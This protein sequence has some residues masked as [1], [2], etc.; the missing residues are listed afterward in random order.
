[1]APKFGCDLEHEVTLVKKFQLSDLLVDLP[2]TRLIGPDVEIQGLACDSRRIKGGELF[3]ALPGTN[4]DGRD[5]IPAALAAGA[6]ALV[7]PQASA[8]EY[9]VPVV[10]GANVRLLMAKIA[11]RFYGDP[12][13]GALVIGITGTNG[14]TTI[15]YLLE[16]IFKQAG[17]RPAVFGTI[18]YRYAER[19]LLAAHTTPESLDLVRMMAEFRAAGANVLI[20]EVSSHALA[21][22]RVAGVHF[23]IAVFTNLTPEHL[24]YHQDME[25]YFA[26]KSRLFAQQPPPAMVVNL[27]D[28]YGV[29]LKKL[30]PQALGYARSASAELGYEELSAGLD[31]QRGT[32]RTPRGQLSLTSPLVGD[33][34]AS[35]LLA[36]VGVACV[37]KIDLSLSAQALAQ[38]PQVPGRL[39][40]VENSPGVLALVDYAHTSDA[41]T[42]VLQALAAIPAKRRVTLVGCGGDRDPRKR[43]LMAA[44]AVTA[45]DLTILT[46]DNPRSEDPQAILNQM[47]QGAL[48]AGACELSPSQLNDSVTGF[49]LVL[50][51]RAAIELAVGCVGKGDIL[52]VAGKGHED[53]QIL[54]QERIHF[55]D[56]EELRRAFGL[57]AVEGSV[58]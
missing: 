51:R 33:F 46:S 23:N 39:E 8:G 22:Y 47:R 45:S 17:Y 49:A 11:Q 4:C 43:P 15:S 48:D 3:F 5:F 58:R 6:T 7:L 19:Q 9:P 24:D 41:L 30:Y 28:A 14:K 13:A 20:L 26:S 25:S 29:R 38:A 37:A 35:N 42:Q 2:E 18:N 52:L 40:R 1:M 27:D 55:D 34:N 56:R 10:V 32:I 12:G 57:L 44:A 21:Q 36:A 50:E 53:Y 31:G 54:G 16:A